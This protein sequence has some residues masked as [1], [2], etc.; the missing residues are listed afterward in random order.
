LDMPKSK[1][2]LAWSKF[3]EKYGPLTWLSVAGQPFLVL[4]SIEAAKELLD[5]R[6]STYVDRPRFVM[7]SEL[8]GLGYITPFSRSGPG[9]RKQRTLLK[10]ALS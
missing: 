4:N 9:W 8:V 1:F 6:G 5:T 7:T 2:A 10:H 3:G